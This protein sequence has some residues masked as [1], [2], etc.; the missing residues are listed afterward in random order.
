MPLQT[1]TTTTLA[2]HH[3]YSLMHL[4]RQATHARH[5]QHSLMQSADGHAS[6]VSFDGDAAAGA[7]HLTSISAAISD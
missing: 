5:H 6:P 3:Q 7:A 2:M 4:F 1:T